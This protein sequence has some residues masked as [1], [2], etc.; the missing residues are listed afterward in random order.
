MLVKFNHIGVN[1]RNLEQ[2]KKL[3]TETYGLEV[4]YS[5][6]VEQE[7]VKVAV[8]PIGDSANF[9]E[10]AEPLDHTD[11]S[12]ATVRRLATSGEGIHQVAL[13]VDD[14]VQYSERLAAKGVVLI[15]RPQTTEGRPQ[16][17]VVHPKSAS[18]ILLEL[19]DKAYYETST[20]AIT[21]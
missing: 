17:M 9:I 16:R 7:G 3:W 13:V 15:K 5:S 4:A 19:L 14:L 8:L 6:V 12:S 10:L 11:M 2:A 21:L 20:G 1:V 18:G